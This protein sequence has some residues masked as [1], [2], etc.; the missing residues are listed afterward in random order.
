MADSKTAELPVQSERR[1]T[2]A[3]P[4]KGRPGGMPAFIPTIEQRNFV[5][6][7]A[8]FRMTWDEIAQLVINPRT[9]RSI[10]KETLGKVFANEL[11]VGK[12]KLKSQI[13]SRYLERLD[14]GEWNAIQFGLKN[15]CDYPDA[16]MNI[17]VMGV[18]GQ[19]IS[20]IEVHFVTASPKVI[21]HE[22]VPLKNGHD[23]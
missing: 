17:P 6:A 16:S 4:T 13:Q 23:R 22:P 1:L 18:D 12:A 3:K 21:E 2:E 10:S 9:E 15:I 11:A 7:M 5:S 20:S 14:A 19:A 8:G